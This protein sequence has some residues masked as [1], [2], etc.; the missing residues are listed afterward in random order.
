MDCER[1]AYR[2][3]E[4]RDIGPRLLGHLAEEGS[5]NG[6]IMGENHG[7]SLYHVKDHT[8]CEEALSKLHSLG[9]LHGHVNKH[10]ILIKDNRAILV[11]FGFARKSQDESACRKEM[12]SLRGALADEFSRGGVEVSSV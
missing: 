9:I 2:W 11:D 8:L 4:S 1:E 6:F 12:E 10:N 3:I 5:F 7:C